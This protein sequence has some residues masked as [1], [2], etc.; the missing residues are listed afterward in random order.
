MGNKR[1]KI[2]MF[3]FKDYHYPILYLLKKMGYEPRLASQ[4]T[5][6]TMNL[7]IRYSPETLCFT[8]KYLLGSY[9][10]ALEN[11]DKTIIIFNANNTGELEK[12]RSICRAGFFGEFHSQIL[13]DMG[14][15]FN[16]VI[17][18]FGEFMWERLSKQGY[19]SEESEQIFDI[20][21]KQMLLYENMR[22]LSFKYRPVAKEKELVEKAYSHLIK[23][24]TY[25]ESIEDLD[26]F[27]QEIENTYKN[28]PVD[29]E[30]EVLKIL[31]V[32]EMAMQ[33]VP[34]LNQRIAYLL[35]DL[36]VEVEITEKFSKYLKRDEMHPII[37]EK[38][39]PYIGHYIGG[40]GL[41]TVG[42]LVYGAENGYDGAIHLFPF[43][44]LPETV[45]KY[46][47]SEVAH[48]FNFPVLTLIFDEHTSRTGMVTRVEAYIDLL[49]ARKE[50]TKE[51]TKEKNRR[52]IS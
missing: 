7:G 43:T 48:D 19:S 28:I 39:R 50:K 4:V 9:I 25:K 40:Q 31:L 51:K 5:D 20:F 6:K 34:F 11:G 1:E 47:V 30:K 18:P 32:G 35:G 16:F 52:K 2:T 10:E 45:A 38:A 42:N 49:R 22:D 36:G 13:F 17:F 3:R 41:E 44:C 15:D 24:L 14:Y 8:S 29:S 21:K 26:E 27:E 33:N 12:L 46:P 37:V 23:K